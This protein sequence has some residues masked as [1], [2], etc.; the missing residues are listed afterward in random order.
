MTTLK[1]QRRSWIRRSYFRRI[2]EQVRNASFGLRVDLSHGR[3]VTYRK[4]LPPKV[5]SPQAGF[6]LG[7]RFIIL[8]TTFGDLDAFGRAVFKD[9]NV[10]H[11]SKS[12]SD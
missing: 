8:T 11:A 3:R 1:Q 2:A 6:F 7:L 12:S 9:P 4:S 10:S 5:R